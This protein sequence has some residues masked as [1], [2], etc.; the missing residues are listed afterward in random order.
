[1][2]MR[3]AAIE[4]GSLEILAA[5]PRAVRALLSVLPPEVLGLPD[6]GG[7]SA[8]DIVAHL[9]DRG[10]IQRERV[11]RLLAQPGT[12]IEDRD[13]Q[14]SLAASGLPAQPLATLLDILDRERANDVAL[15]S[16]LR[17]FELD[18]RGVHS[19]A[20]EISVAN[21][22]NQAAYHD[23]MHL[24]Q[25]AGAIGQSPAAGRGAFAMFG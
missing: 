6:S 1:M 25:I 3:S 15:Y 17:P 24:A 8:H 7:W 9:V 21:L 2:T 18:L 16:R 23:T 4:V 19:V 22:V 11:D 10:R 14:E 5:T 12:A 13:E 20:G